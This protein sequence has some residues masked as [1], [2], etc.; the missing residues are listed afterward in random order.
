MVGSWGQGYVG[1]K[2]FDVRCHVSRITC[3]VSQRKSCVKLQT[4]Y[5]AS[6]TAR[7]KFKI[8]FLRK[9][10]LQKFKFKVLAS[11]WRD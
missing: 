2:M 11:A 9:V 5:S 10:I 8:L 3:Q 1:L 7:I 6:N 4:Q